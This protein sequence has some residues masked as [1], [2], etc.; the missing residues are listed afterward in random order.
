MALVPCPDCARPMDANRSV[1]VFCQRDGGAVPA[2]GQAIPSSAPAKRSWMNTA[3][4][5]WAI[6]LVAALFWG[7]LLVGPLFAPPSPE[8]QVK[9]RSRHAYA[10]AQQFVEDRLKAPGSASFPWYDPSYVTA[11]GVD[12]YTVRAHVD[13]QNSF[14]AKLRA[15]WI[16]RLRWTGPGDFDFQAEEVEVQE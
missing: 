6:A 4:P 5:P 8:E 9:K 14:G 12:R 10:V 13:A 15:S 16:C 7:P 3:V 1:C 11:A 2:D